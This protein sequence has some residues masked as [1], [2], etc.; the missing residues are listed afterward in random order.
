MAIFTGWIMKDPIAEARSG[1]GSGAALG[2]WRFL[3]RWVVPA[4]LLFVLWHSVPATLASVWALF[5]G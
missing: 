2:L 1:G 4:A 3:L 5:E